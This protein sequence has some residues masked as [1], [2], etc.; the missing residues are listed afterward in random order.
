MTLEIGQSEEFSVVAIYENGDVENVTD[1]AL[2]STNFTATEIGT[3][4]HVAKFMNSTCSAKITVIP[5]ACDDENASWSK[6]EEKCKCNEGFEPDKDG[7]CVELPVDVKI[8]LTYPVGKS[9]KVFTSGWVFG[10]KATL[11]ENDEERDITPQIRW[12]GSGDF[13]PDLG[14]VS[15]PIFGREGSNTIEL[16]VVI[17]GKEYKRQFN[18]EAVDP[19]AGGYAS[20]GSIAFCPNDAHGCPT[21]PS[22][23]QGPVTSGSP[24]VTISGLPAARVGDEGVHSACCGANTFKILEGDASVMI[25]GKPAARIGD[26]TQH[27]GGIGKITGTGVNVDCGANEK[28]DGEKM[29]CDCK[30]GFKRNDFGDCVEN[31]DSEGEDEEEEKEERDCGNN[32]YWDKDLEKC[33]C[34]DGFKR[35]EN[36]ICAV[37]PGACTDREYWDKDIEEC[38]CKK[39]YLRDDDGDCLTAR[40]MED[41]LGDEVKKETGAECESMMETCRGLA[42]S[43]DVLRH[44]YNSLYQ[45]LLRNKRRFFKEINDRSSEVCKNTMIGFTYSRTKSLSEKMKVLEREMVGLLIEISYNITVC[46]EISAHLVKS[47]Y[48]TDVTT[49]VK[50]HDTRA[51]LA[52]MSSRLVENGC[53]D[54]DVTQ[55]GDEVAPGQTDPD[56]IGKGGTHSEIGGDGKDND[57]DGQQDEIPISSRFGYNVTIVVYDS[58]TAKDDVFSLSVQGQGPLGVTPAG[59]LRSYGLNLPKGSYTASLHVQYAPDD[60]GTY[61]IT[62][63]YKDTV[64]ATRESDPPQGAVETIPFVVPE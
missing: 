12:G 6:K 56:F 38:K 51:I 58:G 42:N 5:P 21:D 15:K 34:N 23:V 17:D 37:I 19:I 8:E 28:F 1:E 52:S 47:G 54:D 45:K 2:S 16:S 25:N 22:M 50:W 24:N 31:E 57:G 63:L 32:A 60:V 64:I 27:C 59:G 26:K 44:T 13:S 41:K 14:E 7:I 3:F 35:D 48:S 20:V 10:A 36:G 33:K 40:E 9:P 46:K 29:S 61:T 55:M 18:I 39:P 43:V 11:T 4:S 30:K 53:N 62:I 49:W